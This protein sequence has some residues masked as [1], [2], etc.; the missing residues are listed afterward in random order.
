MFA[1][2]TLDLI[3]SSDEHS[4]SGNLDK[5]LLTA[6]KMLDLVRSKRILSLQAL[7]LMQTTTGDDSFGLRI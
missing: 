2:F 5:L 1:T 3:F 7:E 6:V 4:Y